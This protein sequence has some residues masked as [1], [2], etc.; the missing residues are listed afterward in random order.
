[1]RTLCF[2]KT[3][4]QIAE[5]TRTLCFPN[6]PPR[7]AESMLL[8][9][10]RFCLLPVKWARSQLLL[11]SCIWLQLS[12]LKFPLPPALLTWGC[13][14]PELAISCSHGSCGRAAPPNSGK[15]PRLPCGQSLCPLLCGPRGKLTSDGHTAGQGQPSDGFH[16]SEAAP[17][18]RAW[19]VGGGL[20]H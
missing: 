18:A 6:M 1:M 5:S 13:R 8:L 19:K 10:P 12:K 11:S 20:C 15:P 14:E 4:P 16:T 2:P 3:P 7:I 17:S 9:A